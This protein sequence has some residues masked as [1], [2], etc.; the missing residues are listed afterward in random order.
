MGLQ[1][2][3]RE[4]HQG[5]TACSS[6]FSHVTR[7]NKGFSRHRPEVIVGAVESLTNMVLVSFVFV[8][9]E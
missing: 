9:F 8:T 1:L 3:G 5:I 7:R 2:R 4:R 6:I